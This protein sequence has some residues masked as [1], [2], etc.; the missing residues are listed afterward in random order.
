L[1]K[2]LPQFMNMCEPRNLVPSENYKFN[3]FWFCAK[4][5][6]PGTLINLVKHLKIES[7]EL[8]L[9]FFQK[10]LLN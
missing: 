1:N 8:K 5:F 10:P 9:K 7:V 6:T 2:K 3:D 4:V